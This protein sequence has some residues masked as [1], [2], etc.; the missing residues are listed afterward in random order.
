[1]TIQPEFYIKDNTPVKLDKNLSAEGVCLMKCQSE[2]C[3]NSACCP[4][5]RSTAYYRLKS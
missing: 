2:G 4:Q 3:K 1:M 5:V